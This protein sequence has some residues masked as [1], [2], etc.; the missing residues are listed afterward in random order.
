[1]QFGNAIVQNAAHRIERTKDQDSISGAC[2][3]NGCFEGFLRRQVLAGFHV[4]A[5]IHLPPS[6]FQL[7]C[8][9][10]PGQWQICEIPS[11][12]HGQNFLKHAG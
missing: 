12:N 10:R 2:R 1:M 5:G 8:R 7:G 9:R 3:C 4:L 6:A 11:I